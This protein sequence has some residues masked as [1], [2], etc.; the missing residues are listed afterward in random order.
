MKLNFIK[1][2]FPKVIKKENKPPLP[3]TEEIYL[4]Y[5]FPPHTYLKKVSD[6]FLLKILMPYINE[7][8]I[9]DKKIKGII[10]YYGLPLRKNEIT[11]FKTI[12]DVEKLYEYKIIN[13]YLDLLDLPQYQVNRIFNILSNP[14]G[15]QINE[16]KD[17]LEE[18]NY[19]PKLYRAYS[20]FLLL[21]E[22]ETV[23]MKSAQKVISW[24]EAFVYSITET[25]RLFLE[26]ASRNPAQFIFL[27]ITFVVL[28]ILF[29][30]LQ[31]ALSMFGKV[32][33]AL[34]STQLVNITNI[35]NI[36]V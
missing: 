17:S 26:F 10:I 16:F 11:K 18:I 30:V 22:K 9:N 12:N 7:Y 14:M 24:K 1:I 25:S 13:F 27:L 35:T 15:I 21:K 8:E 33:E 23:L 19:Y 20:I 31:G 6:R 29:F 28:I 36:T 5:H 4:I 34:V 2:D 32:S 3:K